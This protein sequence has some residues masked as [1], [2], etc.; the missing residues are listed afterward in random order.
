[1]FGAIE[2]GDFGF[3]DVGLE[4]GGEFVVDGFGEVAEEFIGGADFALSVG[5]RQVRWVGAMAMS[6]GVWN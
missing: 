3:G 1:M 4:V 5:V 2:V 6:S